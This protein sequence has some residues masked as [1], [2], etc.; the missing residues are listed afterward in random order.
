[1]S[2]VRADIHSSKEGPWLR[3]PLDNPWLLRLKETSLRGDHPESVVGPQVFCVDEDTFASWSMNLSI[4][5]SLST[6][7]V[8]MHGFLVGKQNLQHTL[9]L[10]W[11]YPFVAYAFITYFICIHTWALFSEN[12]KGLWLCI[13]HSKMGSER[14]NTLP[15]KF[16]LPRVD[17]LVALHSKISPCKKNNFIC[18][19]GRILDL[20]TTPIDVSALVALSQNITHHSDVSHSKT[21]SWLQLLKSMRSS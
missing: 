11:S 19:Y 6:H 1:M 14:R 12:P 20:L 3:G 4:F 5:K 13:E 2:H 18:R 9:I 8:R 16:K 21:S 10:Q 15:L 17:T 7:L